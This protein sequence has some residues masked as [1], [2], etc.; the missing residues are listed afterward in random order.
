MKRLII[1]AS[2]I[3]IAS[4]ASA[5]PTVYNPFTKKP[6]YVGTN[7]STGLKAR[8]AWSS[9]INYSGA[10]L[11]S[12]S[13]ASWVAQA[14]SG[15]LNKIPTQQAAFWTQVAR[16]ITGPKG[17]T[18]TAGSVIYEVFGAPAG[19]TG[20]D[21]DWAFDT[22][23]LAKVYYRSGG[24][25]GE[26]NAIR[27]PEGPTGSQGAASTVA[28]PTGQQGPQG[29][30]GTVS[31]ATGIE[32]AQGTT[33]QGIVMYEG[34]SKGTNTATFRIYTGGNSSNHVADIRDDGIYFDG[35]KVGANVDLSD[36]QNQPMTQTVSGFVATTIK[37][38]ITEIQTYF[39]SR[40]ASL[41]AAL[42]QHGILPPASMAVDKTSLVFA[43]TSTGSYRTGTWTITAGTFRNLS[44]NNWTIAGSGAANFKNWSGCSNQVI[45]VSGTCT[46]TARFQPAVQ[47][48]YSSVVTMASNDPATAKTIRLSG[49]SPAPPAT[50]YYPGGYTSADFATSD[51]GG[52][53][54]IQIATRVIAGM[55]GNV[56]ELGVNLL[57]VSATACKLAIYDNQPFGSAV[58]STGAAFTPATGWNSVA[59]TP[60]AITSGT[61]VRVAMLCDGNYTIGK[62]ASATDGSYRAG[63]NYAAFPT[64]SVTWDANISFG[65]RMKVE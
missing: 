38:A 34:S 22:S 1:A 14:V 32:I 10:N 33:A 28:G 6:D 40:I 41:L 8:G 15:N 52:G 58:L 64:G 39:A 55:S 21:G 27:G 48:T 35:T 30:T 3:L 46:T 16:S 44:T 63:M 53:S 25:W 45:P 54:T 37:T 24:T 56:T 9:L 43:N 36:A 5:L 18:G 11:V 62:H 26:V 31:S 23:V 51:G 17:D 13:S 61:T 49:T 42:V 50:Y 19:G 29:A 47:G 60:Y 2:L 57:T 7:T 4:L 65:F 12:Y 20:V 59:I